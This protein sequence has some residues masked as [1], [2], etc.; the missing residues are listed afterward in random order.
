MSDNDLLV[1]SSSQHESELV[2]ENGLDR[3]DGQSFRVEAMFLVEV[4]VAN[5][6]IAA[7]NEQS[8]GGEGREGEA[9]AMA[10][11][12]WPCHHFK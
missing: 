7:R 12:G 8:K 6:L 4:E 3:R 2:A 9:I 1:E 11:G 10:K 5:T